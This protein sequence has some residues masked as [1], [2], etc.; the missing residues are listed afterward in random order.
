[1]NPKLRFAIFLSQ[2]ALLVGCGALTAQFKQAEEA[3]ENQPR[4]KLRIIANSFVK[5]I[6][7]KDCIDW[8]APGSGTVF[9]GI[10]GSS[11]YRGRSLDMPLPPSSVNPAGMGEMYVAANKPITLVFE[12]GPDSSYFCSVSGSFT[13]EKEK[14]YEATLVLDIPKNKCFFRL[15]ELQETRIPI[16]ISEAKSCN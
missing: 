7:N 9:G 16:K 13:P 4:A 15:N 3:K 2:L 5:A 8:E 6:P 11:G 14:N 10:V 12:T 1:M